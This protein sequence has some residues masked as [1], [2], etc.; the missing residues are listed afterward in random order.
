ML[1]GNHDLNVMDR[2]NPARLDLPTSPKK[3][4][5]QIRAISALEAVQGSRVRLLDSRNNRL[6]ASLSEA[7]K[8]HLEDIAAFADQGSFRLSGSLAE[9]W[10][11]SFPMVQPPETEN[12]LGIILLNSNVEAHFSFTNALGL[13]STEQARAIDII[14]GL[15]PRAYWIVALHHHV[16]EYPKRAKALSQRIGTA[17]INGSW[18]V[19]RLRR[20][21]DRAVVMHGHRHIDWIG[22]YGGLSIVSAPS[23]VMEV[24]DE[25]ETYFYIHT[26]ATQETAV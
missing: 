4:L 14:A 19:R 24:T 3:R 7:L 25:C 9:M 1:L 15:Y 2:A 8:P 23:P 10:A 13:V 21:A 16:V 20:L 5:R 11:T 18:F 12:G 17:L 22:E 6:G 26:L